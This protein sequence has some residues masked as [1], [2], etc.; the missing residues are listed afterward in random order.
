MG[1]HNNA[2]V[3]ATFSG[4]FEPYQ[5]DRGSVEHA[6]T[7][8]SKDSRDTIEADLGKFVQSADEYLK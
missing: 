7:F 6:K 3:N 8:K 1:N 2:A 5:S 4:E